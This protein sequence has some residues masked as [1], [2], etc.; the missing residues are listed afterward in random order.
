M[1]V[2]GLGWGCH[3]KETWVPGWKRWGFTFRRPAFG[4]LLTHRVVSQST[5]FEGS[6]AL[7]SVHWEHSCDKELAEH[8][9]SCCFNV[10]SRELSSSIG[11]QRTWSIWLHHKSWRQ[12]DALGSW[13]VFTTVADISSHAR[14]VTFARLV[15]FVSVVRHSR[16]QGNWLCPLQSSLFWSR[17]QWL[18]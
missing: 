10:D 7:S 15:E 9:K 5:S 13:G 18:S 17:N 3:V 6:K 1:D 14:R 2:S 8:L 16:L 12:T 11:R 4:F